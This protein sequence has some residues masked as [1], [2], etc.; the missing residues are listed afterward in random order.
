MRPSRTREERKNLQ[1]GPSDLRDQRFGQ[2][3]LAGSPKREEQLRDAKSFENLAI[4]DEETEKL[5]AYLLKRKRDIEEKMRALEQGDSEITQKI[6]KEMHGKENQ[7]LAMIEKGQ[8][9]GQKM[10]VSPTISQSDHLKP[11]QSTE[12]DR[13]KR[14]RLREEERRLRQAGN[15]NS[16]YQVGLD[17]SPVNFNVKNEENNRP[18]IPNPKLSGPTR[19]SPE[20]NQFDLSPV[21]R[22]KNG[23]RINSANLPYEEQPNS[24]NFSSKLQ[25]FFQAPETRENQNQEPNAV[26]K[27][28]QQIASKN[29]LKSNDAD[30]MSNPKLPGYS[31]SVDQYSEKLEKQRKYKEMLDGQVKEKQVYQSIDKEPT[32]VQPMKK[33]ENNFLENEEKK[34][35]YADQL[36]KQIIENEKKRALEQKQKIDEN[37]FIRNHELERQR[38]PSQNDIQKLI[39]M[40]K[41]RK[42]KEELDNQVNEKLNQKQRD[43]SPGHFPKSRPSFREQ[44]RNYSEQHPEISAPEHIQTQGDNPAVNEMQYY[45]DEHAGIGHDPLAH[46]KLSASPHSHEPLKRRR[47]DM[48]HEHSEGQPYANK[49]VNVLSKMEDEDNKRKQRE[50]LQKQQIAEELRKQM[51]EKEEKKRLEKKRIQ[52]EELREME[53]FEREQKLIQQREELKKRQNVT[54]NNPQQAAPQNKP[55]KPNAIEET[56]NPQQNRDNIQDQSIR[57][58]PPLSHNKFKEDKSIISGNLQQA[59]EFAGNNYPLTQQSSPKQQRNSHLQGQFPPYPGL[60]PQEQFPGQ[61]PNMYAQYPPFYP[62]DPAQL[63]EFGKLQ[64][65]P[66]FYYPPYMYPFHPFFFPPQHPMANFYQPTPQDLNRFKGMLQ[67]IEEQRNR[68]DLLAQE[69]NVLENKLTEIQKEKIQYQREIEKLR[70]M[71]QNDPKLQD[72]LVES[73][74]YHSQTDP[75]AHRNAIIASQILGPE[76]LYKIPLQLNASNIHQYGGVADSGKSKKQEF[77]TP[78][79]FVSPKRGH[80]RSQIQNSILGRMPNESALSMKSLATESYLIE[81]NNE[82]ERSFLKD[83]EAFKELHRQ[84]FQL[85]S[86]PNDRIHQT[87]SSI[88]FNMSKETSM[89]GLE[90]AAGYP[91]HNLDSKKPN[92]SQFATGLDRDH[93]EADTQAQMMNPDQILTFHPINNKLTSNA[94]PDV[95]AEK[96]ATGIR[97]SQQGPHQFKPSDQLSQFM[98]PKDGFGHKNFT[99][100]SVSP[101]LASL[102]PASTNRN[103]FHHELRG[104]QGFSNLSNRNDPNDPANRPV[105]LKNYNI[106]DFLT[107]KEILFGQNSKLNDFYTN[108]IS[109]NVS[110][111]MESPFK[112]QIDPLLVEKETYKKEVKMQEMK[113]DRS[114]VIADEDDYDY[115]HQNISHD[116]GL[117]ELRE[118]LNFRSRYPKNSIEESESKHSEFLQKS[119]PINLNEQYTTSSLVVSQEISNQ[120]LQQKKIEGVSEKASLCVKKSQV[121][122]PNAR[123]SG[124]IT[125]S[126]SSVVSKLGLLRKDRSQGKLELVDP[127]VPEEKK[128]EPKEVVSSPIKYSNYSIKEEPNMENLFSDYKYQEDKIDPPVLPEN[129]ISTNNEV[130]KITYSPQKPPRNSAIKNPQS[131]MLRDINQTSETSTFDKHSDD[132]I[133]RNPFEYKEFESLKRNYVN[134]LANDSGDRIHSQRDPY[135]L[136]FSG[137]KRTLDELKYESMNEKEIENHPNYGNINY[138]PYNSEQS[139]NSS[140]PGGERGRNRKIKTIDP[141]ARVSEPNTYSI[142]KTIKE[143]E[144]KDSI[145]NHNVPLNV[146]SREIR[147]STENKYISNK[148]RSQMILDRLTNLLG[149]LGGD[150]NL[151]AGSAENTQYFLGEG[152]DDRINEVRESFEETK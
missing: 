41:K 34:R 16:A 72:Q 35:E 94:K 70:V 13:E 149:N 137:K 131:G 144:R 58:E 47:S 12:Q 89:A 110:S 66:P 86:P 93:K 100:M 140:N 79:H 102:F 95:Q 82:L 18:N 127:Q 103:D 123:E 71:L 109:R 22:Q 39:E 5:E 139:W 8:Q 7:K 148:E 21:I 3:A 42:Y 33:L 128:E 40:E 88:R 77:K 90:N 84:A 114:L 150:F 125:S 126:D 26:P 119:D 132:L 135:E 141:F 61:F 20:K 53:K 74:L 62:Q 24:I 87:P 129:K 120:L 130:D 81:N 52:E 111:R 91:M 14:L 57:Q 46:P 138:N 105:T 44:Q 9:L 97:S 92:R 68:K 27:N 151:D 124:Q 101:D 59:R 2:N 143:E 64:M 49:E 85:S 122:A 147:T 1:M 23:G 136:P 19:L 37:P 63:A 31:N 117:E 60:F 80:D 152:N 113:S 78:G 98:S 107:E 4:N 75:N 48:F 6:E 134:H 104:L 73:I 55:E 67:D 54:E 118:Q 96:T 116:N 83:L 146:E 17:K 25:N 38:Q 133:T 115:E 145:S 142:D 56:L 112:E 45:M 76:I 29:Q 28:L 30:L 15:Q 106:A 43:H 121:L 51:Q 50:K 36:M 32:L 99:S 65:P 108:D 11:F 69:K 10:P